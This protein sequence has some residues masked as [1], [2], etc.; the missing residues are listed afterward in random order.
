MIRKRTYMGIIL[1]M[2]IM[3]AIGYLCFLRV[4]TVSLQIAG[5]TPCINICTAQSKNTIMLWQN[6]GGGKLFFPSFLCES[7]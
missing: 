1:A 7:P 4:N 2:M 6:A 5:E 3:V